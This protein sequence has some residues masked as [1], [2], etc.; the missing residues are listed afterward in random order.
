MAY[1]HERADALRRQ[2][3]SASIDA[4]LLPE[5]KVDKQAPHLK[6]LDLYKEKLLEFVSL[7]DVYKVRSLL[8][9][10]PALPKYRD[11]TQFRFKMH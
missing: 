11:A 5:P 4:S 9:H 1:D 10:A 6:N 7:G 3:S 2:E 8:E